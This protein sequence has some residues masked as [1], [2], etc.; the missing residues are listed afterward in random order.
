MSR[1]LAAIYVAGVV[2]GVIVMRDPLRPRLVTALVW[3]LGPLAFV[4]V[5]AILVVTAAVLW[6]VTFLATAAVVAALAWLVT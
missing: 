2:L 3:P 5:L 1:V 4:V 6:P